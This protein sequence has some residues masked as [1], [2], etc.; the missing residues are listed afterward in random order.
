M[1]DYSYSMANF[2]VSDQATSPPE[3]T[4]EAWERN[5]RN[6]IRLDAINALNT[7]IGRLVEVDIDNDTIISLYN[8]QTR[9]YAE[10]ED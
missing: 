2:K 8:L 6:D 1:N 10:M 5:N 9:L 7:A 3:P 4:D